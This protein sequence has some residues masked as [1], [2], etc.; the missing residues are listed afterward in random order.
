MAAANADK[1]REDFI[2]AQARRMLDL[3]VKLAPVPKG[4]QDAYKVSKETDK[5]LSMVDTTLSS[6]TLSASDNNINRLASI[7]RNLRNDLATLNRK[8]ENWWVH[9]SGVN[10]F[11][12]GDSTKAIQLLE[13]QRKHLL[14][15]REASDGLHT[16]VGVAFA[17][18]VADVKGLAKLYIP[19]IVALDGIVAKEARN[20]FSACQNLIDSIL[21]KVERV[22]RQV[23]DMNKAIDRFLSLINS[24]DQREA[25]K[26]IESPR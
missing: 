1:A 4:V 10:L 22:I 7:A 23:A 2:K 15:L 8:D 25:L 3:L 24:K 5:A 11:S 18:T 14:A 20:D 6:G 17:A 16:L 13:Q 26:A 21:A 12:R 19:S 9:T